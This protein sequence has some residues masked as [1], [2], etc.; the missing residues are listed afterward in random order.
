MGRTY[1]QPSS[2]TKVANV[3]IKKDT[4]NSELIPYL[5][6]CCFSPSKS[7]FLKAVKHGNFLTWPG[8]TPSNVE[9]YYEN[10][11]FVAKGHLNQERKNLQSTKLLHQKIPSPTEEAIMHDDFFPA[12]EGTKPTNYCMV[13]MIPFE[14]NHTGYSDITGRFPYA[15]SRGNQYLLVIYDWD[16]NAIL[17]QPIKSRRA[18][19]IKTAFNKIVL[20]LES[21]GAKPSY[22]ILDNEVSGELKAALKHHDIHYQLAPPHQ[23][24]RNAAER[25]IQTYKNHFIAGLASTDPDFPIT[26]WDRLTDQGN[27]TLNLL[28]NARLN[29]RLS[30]HAFLNG[31]FDFN[32]TPLAPPGT[33]LIIHEKPSQRKTWAPHG[34]FAWYVGPALEHY[35]CIRAFVPA[36]FKERI[37]DTAQ[38]FPHSIKLPSTSDADY[39]QQAADDILSI[40]A[41]PTPTLPYL[42]SG[43]E[44]RSAIAKTAVL[45][46]RSLK[47]PPSLLKTIDS[48]ATFSSESPN[49]SHA[50]HHVSLPRVQPPLPPFPH[51]PFK[52]C[53]LQHIIAT[54]IFQPSVHHIYNKVTGKR[55]T[56]ETLLNGPDKDIWNKAV[57]N[58]IGRLTKGNIHGV[59]YTEMMEFIPKSCVPTNRDVT[60]ASMVFDFRPLKS[61]PYRCRIVA[62][63]D[64]LTYD[65]DA[66]SPATSMLETKILLNSVISDARHGAKFMSADLKD[67]FLATP[68][69]T[70]EYMRLQM[71]LIPE[72]IQSKYNLRA[73]APKGYV[74]IRIIKGI[75]GLKQAALLAYQQLVTFLQ[76]NGYLPVPN[77]VGMWKHKTRK[78]I[79]CLCVDDFG[80]KYFSKDDIDHLLTALEKHYKVSKDWAGQHFCGLTL[81]WHYHQGYVDISMPGY[82]DKVLH[83]YQHQ[84]PTKPELS[85]HQHT[86]PA[87]GQ[88]IQMA[89]VD[90]TPPLNPKATKR[91]Q[92]IIG[93]LLYYARAIDN[94]M[95]TA[96]NEISA[97]QSKPTQK[98]LHATT[99]L[100]DYAATYPNTTIR[101]YA[102]DMILHAE[103][104]AAYLVLPNARSRIAGLFYLSDR[105]HPSN[106]P[107]PPRNGPI[108]IIC[109]TLRHVVAS[110]AEAE[111]GGLFHNTREAIPIR[112]TLIALGH[113]QPA[114][115]IKTDNS[116][117]LSFVKANIKQKRSKSWDMRYNWLRDRLLLK[118]FYFHWDKGIHNEAD[119]HTKHHPPKHHLS[120][121]HKYVFVPNSARH[122]I[123][124]A[125]CVKLISKAARVC[126]YPGVSRLSQ[127]PFAD[128][129]SHFS[130][131]QV[132]YS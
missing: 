28:R 102:S 128:V 97:V 60:Y 38:F 55:E 8:L 92:G 81:D 45:L 109:K 18:S 58:E 124:L 77:T 119:Y 44:L 40:L 4:T 96:I 37:T 62:G 11:I 6:G 9:K 42:E 98:T 89:P 57:S 47:K 66:S 39:L 75:Y 116:T 63:G 19:D 71:K 107:N 87:Y 24:R 125:H 120:N 90:N 48:L 113:A 36:T 106:I 103:S 80:I 5:Q 94:T 70:P 16:S 126:S 117:A 84:S 27:I 101:F 112:R 74:Y 52:Q 68:M 1:P 130:L 115:P 86:E 121:R 56:P 41:K 73:L 53:A 25:A 82:I 54:E 51:S 108:L 12:Q 123:Q 49:I 122:K 50:G 111:T 61:E 15:S 83:K 104:D 88:R 79:F 91:I 21:R 69:S 95:L 29:P 26:E 85:P 33:K 23:H 10:N 34:V 31:M 131:P 7:T 65:A 22:F 118:D 132:I 105:Q 13:A 59:S 114:T 67:F 43:P 17:A 64:K 35:R 14:A 32:K 99:K 93:S 46:H 2:P 129:A 100:L 72:D 20:H 30:S 3:I 110:A 127:T 78:T 76:P